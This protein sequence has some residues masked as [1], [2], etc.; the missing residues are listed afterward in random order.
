MQTVISASRRTDIPAFYLDWFISRLRVGEFRL[1]NP[2]NGRERVVQVSRASVHSL[3]F[4]SKNY[5]PLL[6]RLPELRG[7]NLFFQFTLN[8]ED[9][10]LEPGVPPLAERREQMRLLAGIF[11]P[12]AVRWRFDPVACYESGGGK[13]DNL[14]GFESLLDFAAGI[15]LRACTVSFMDPYRKIDKR[16]KQVPGFRFI[17]PDHGRMVETASRMAAQAAGRGIRLSTCCEQELARSGIDNLSGGGCIDHALLAGLYG[18]SLSHVPDRGQ[19]RSAGCLCHESIDIGSYREQPC[20]GGCLY[21]YANP[22]IR[23]RS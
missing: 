14:G 3:V 22:L 12:Q 15:G 17:Y 19:R 10:L 21:C 2:F 9:K 7:W 18:G 11:G 16:E 1:S 13:R 6:G 5:G 8:S 23:W 4:W 20:R